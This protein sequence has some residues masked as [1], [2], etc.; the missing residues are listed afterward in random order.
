MSIEGVKIMIHIVWEFTVDP[1]NIDEFEKHYGSKGT[2]AVFFGLSED[3]YG[4]LLLKDDSVP[5]RYLTIDQ[6][7]DS[8]AFESFKS[9]N[10]KRYTELDARLERL[11]SYENKIGIFDI[12]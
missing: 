8:A 12:V 10:F 2:W 5:F 4:T 11:T 6:W 1:L 3:Y 7:R 9:Q